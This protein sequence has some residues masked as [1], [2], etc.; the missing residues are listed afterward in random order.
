M[1]NLLENTRTIIAAI[2]QSNVA[3][4]W[5][6]L[7]MDLFC[8]TQIQVSVSLPTHSEQYYTS[9]RH[10]LPIW[11][12]LTNESLL[13]VRQCVC[14]RHEKEIFV[15]ELWLNMRIIS[16]YRGPEL[17]LKKTFLEWLF[18]EVIVFVEFNTTVVIKRCFI[19]M[20]V[21]ADY[22]I[23]FSRWLRRS[24]SIYFMVMS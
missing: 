17:N 7:I 13:N 10:P 21:E 19:S 1:S 9:A 20:P 8:F 23:L 16:I 22:V 24:N 3:R 5:L 18:K 14:T 15:D 12:C 4:V 2:I 6:Q 11:S